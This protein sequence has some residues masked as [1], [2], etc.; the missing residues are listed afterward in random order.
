[1]I[2]SISF[3]FYNTLVQFWP[4]LDEIQQAAC[5]ELGLNVSKSNLEHGYSVADGYFNKENGRRSLS[6]R[7]AKERSEFFARYEQMILEN[8]GLP[9]SLDLASQVWEMAMTIPKD[10]V[11]FDDTIPVLSALRGGGYRLG[12]L[13]NLRRDIGELC[14]RLGLAQYLDFCINAEEA[15]AEKPHSPMFLAALERVSVDADEALH[16]GDQFESDVLGA[17]AVGMHG[18]LID[19]G[20]WHDNVPDCPRIA[21]LSELDTLLA[22]APNSLMMNHHK[23]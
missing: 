13:T 11:P 12:V 5:H 15:G 17:R 4:P 8:A 7:S 10:F 14:S 22:G 21:S 2:K 3:D 9:V 18:V 19:R 1:M 20:G 6:S 23:A 16:V